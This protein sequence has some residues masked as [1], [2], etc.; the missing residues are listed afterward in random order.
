MAGRSSNAKDAKGSGL[1]K[2]SMA[3]SWSR[4]WR[5]SLALLMCLVFS[6]WYLVIWC[7]LFGWFRLVLN[8]V[9]KLRNNKSFLKEY[10]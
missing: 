6:V 4:V 2:D 9:F 1:Q 3:V 5:V 7:L 8:L 10:R